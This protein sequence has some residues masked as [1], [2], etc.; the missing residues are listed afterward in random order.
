MPEIVYQGPS[1]EEL[2]ANQ[3]KLDLFIENSEKQNKTFTDALQVQIDNAAAT[4]KTLTDELAALKTS[5]QNT[6]ASYSGPAAGQTYAVTTKQTDPENAQ[7]TTTIKPKK[8]DKNKSTLKVSQNSVQNTS[9][10]GVNVG[11]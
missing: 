7:T 8:K 1:Q 5:H 10:S 9:G 3:A 6:V 11:V 4:T 2:D